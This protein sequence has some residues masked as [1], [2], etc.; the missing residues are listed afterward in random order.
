M[1]RHFGETDDLAETGYVLTDG[2]FVD[3]SGRHYA[4]GYV[5]RGNRFVPKPG[6]PDDLQGHR[7]VDHRELPDKVQDALGTEAGGPT[8]WAFI[9]ETGAIR[10]MPGTGFLV[11]RMP[12]IEAVSRIVREWHHAFGREPMYVDAVTEAGGVR[13]SREFHEPTLEEVMEYLEGL[14]RSPGLSGRSP[15]LADVWKEYLERL[16]AAGREMGVSELVQEAGGGWEDHGTPSKWA[17]WRWRS[18]TQ[19]IRRRALSGVGHLM[20]W[21]CIRVIDVQEFMDSLHER[22]LGIYWSYDQA[23]AVC[24]EGVGTYDLVVGALVHPDA[25]DYRE[26]LR[27]NFTPGMGEV[28]AEVT[29][30]KGSPV[31]VFEVSGAPGTGLGAPVPATI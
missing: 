22:P 17:A 10:M 19:D 2:T 23:G 15:A 18:L 14:F 1:L 5:R 8:M 28:E 7:Y 25:V 27:A 16:R 20:L 4:D 30:L 29:L 12:T 26:T 13:E 31:R 6:R 3:L 11:A 24:H 9:R 21:R